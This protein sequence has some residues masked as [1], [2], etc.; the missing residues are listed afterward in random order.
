MCYVARRYE[1][2]NYEVLRKSLRAYRPRDVCEAGQVLMNKKCGWSLDFLAV[3]AVVVVFSLLPHQ[4]FDAVGFC[5]KKGSRGVR[6]VVL[7]ISKYVFSG[8]R[9]NLTSRVNLENGQLNKKAKENN[10][11]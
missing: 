9:L 8:T 6:S 11:N 4:C 1:G 7:A 10:E 3:I 2:K 5:N